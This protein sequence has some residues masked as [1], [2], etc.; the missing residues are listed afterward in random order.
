MHQPPGFVDRRCPDFVCRLKKSLYGLKQAPRAWYTRF[1]TFITSHG[2]K[3]SA[4]N[5]SVFVYQQDPSNIAYLLLYVDDIVL[6]ASNEKLLQSI[7]GNLS[8][9]FAMTDLGR[10]HHF[11]GI[12]VDQLKNGIFLSQQQYAKDIISRASMTAC[13][14]CTTPVDLSSKLSASDGPRFSDPTLYRSLAG[15]LQYLTFTRPDISYAM[16]Q[17]CL[18]MHDPRDAHYSFMKRIIRYIQG[19]IDYGIRMVK[20]RTNELV[21]YSDAYWGGCPDSRRSTSGYC[22][23]LGDNLISWSSKRQP[24]VSHS[25]AKAEYRGVASAVAEATWIR[26]LLLEL[27]TPLRQAS[28]IYCDNVSAVYLSDNPV[29]HQRTKHIEIGI[30][31][32]RDKVR[33]GD[34]RV[35]HVPSSLKYADIFMKGLSKQLF[36]SFRTSLSVCPPPVQTAG[37]S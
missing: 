13:K 8:R 33:V 1:A 32:V 23:F 37:E 4:C 27:H 21:E 30:H 6:T 26:N 18:F 3:S 5:H 2:F 9:E 22:V 29:Q 36:Q 10:L 24:T 25:S 12:K 15:A 14:P 7:I 19:T 28:I 35:L 31:F 11:L 16:Q 34:I 20:S 17:I